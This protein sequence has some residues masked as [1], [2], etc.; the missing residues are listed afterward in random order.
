MNWL[1]NSKEKLEKMK[2]EMD[3]NVFFFDSRSD[4]NGEE[5]EEIIKRLK[6]LSDNFKD[7][8]MNHKSVIII[9]KKIVIEDLEE[10]DK[11]LKKL[12]NRKN[13]AVELDDFSYYP[14]PSN[15]RFSIRFKVEEE[16]P[17]AV[18]IHSLSGKEIYVENYDSFV[19][20]FKSEIDVSKHESGIYLLEILQG[21]KVTNK[22]LII[23]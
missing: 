20:T 8:D 4:E 17:L 3:A 11:E 22:K 10:S 16:G 12:S 5:R 13:E 1:V 19:G 2:G 9:T 14:N 18:R 7:F 21:N 23:E 15:G 6:D